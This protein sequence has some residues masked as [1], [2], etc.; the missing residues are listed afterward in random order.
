MPSQREIYGK[1]SRMNGVNDLAKLVAEGTA[2]SD[3]FREFFK[4][5]L[6]VTIR[7]AKSY[8]VDERELANEV[9]LKLINHAVELVGRHENELRSWIFRTAVRTALDY[10]RKEKRYRKRF[11]QIEATDEDNSEN[12][13][14]GVAIDQSLDPFEQCAETEERERFFRKLNAVLAE[15]GAG[16]E[17]RKAH[18]WIF[19]RNFE[20]W[21]YKQIA[22][23]LR[24]PV[25][26][27]NM[28]L[29]R[30][31]IYLRD[32]IG[33]ILSV[34][35]PRTKLVGPTDQSGKARVGS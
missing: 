13:L 23:Q 35:R 7:I 26:K 34:A 33:E 18:V 22:R 14:E 3:E 12:L 25:T 2:T 5:V 17:V 32:H 10:T 4:L 27:V 9:F 1:R 15:Y 21:S 6:Y 8:H 19:L 28:A 30:V 24:I 11:V 16:S 31:K 29:Y 20:G